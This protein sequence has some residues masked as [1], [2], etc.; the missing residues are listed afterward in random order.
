MARLLI[1]IAALAS[2]LASAARSAHAQ[3][4]SSWPRAGTPLVRGE[5]TSMSPTSDISSAACAPRLRDPRTGREY[6]LKHS[7]VR[8]TVAQHQ[9]GAT[10]HTTTRLL[11][12]V[13]DYA[14]LEA[15]GDTLSTRVVAVDCTTSRVVTRRAGT[16]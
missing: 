13:G 7:S 6:M 3:T 8:T 9:S 11:R 15:K 1:G 10:T 2:L 5:E 14:R 4:V 12:A 16:Q